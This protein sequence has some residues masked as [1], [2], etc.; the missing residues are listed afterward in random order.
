MDSQKTLKSFKEISTNNENEGIDMTYST[1]LLIACAAVFLLNNQFAYANPATPAPEKLKKIEVLNTNNDAFFLKNAHGVHG[2][3]DV[4]YLRTLREYVEDTGFQ[5]KPTS[6]R[7]MII[8][9]LEWVTSQW[10]HDGMNQPP[11]HFRALEI[12]KSVHQTGARYRCVEYGI[13]LSEVLQAYGLITRKVAIYSNDVA[14]GGLGMGHVAMEVWSNSLKKWLFLDPQFG[15][16]IT[17]K[18]SKVPLNYFEIY[19][20]RKIGW[21]NLAIHFVID[22]PGGNEKMTS[23]YRD[24]LE[25]YFG[26]MLVTPAKNQPRIALLLNNKK[27]SLTFQAL[28]TNRIVYTQD[29]QL[30]YFDQNRVSVDF[31]YRGEQPIFQKVAEEHGIETEEDYLNKMAYFAAYPSFTVHLTQAMPVFSHFEFRIGRD[32]EW[33]DIEGSTLDWDADKELNFIEI[34]AENQLGQHGPSTFFEISYK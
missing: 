22:H 23:T 34:R 14:Y 17:A 32:G 28:P 24:F 13:V 19:K 25:N 33:Q 4:R 20:A 6:E 29:P 15:A 18:G 10:Q 26:H 21:D 2:E 8:D 12:L 9:A 16:Y 5:P 31:E 30:V 27:Q 1:K 3:F 11:K 7:T